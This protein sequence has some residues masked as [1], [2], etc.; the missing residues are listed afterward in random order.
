MT[1]TAVRVLSLQNGWRQSQS[2]GHACMHVEA[3]FH[4]RA[5][6]VE[7]LREQALFPEAGSFLPLLYLF[8]YFFPYHQITGAGSPLPTPEQLTIQALWGSLRYSEGYRWC[9]IAEKEAQRTCQEGALT[10][11]LIAMGGTGRIPGECL[12]AVKEVHRR[13]K[14]CTRRVL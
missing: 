7:K 11:T 12:S 9:F 5:L 3:F 1:A 6:V 2:H 14:G 13:Y 8:I 10:L 4:A